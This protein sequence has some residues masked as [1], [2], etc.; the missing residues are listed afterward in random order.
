[1]C[2]FIIISIIFLGLIFWSFWSVIFFRLWDFPSLKVRKCFLFWRSECPKCHHNLT[3]VNLVPVL[4]FLFQWWK[5]AFCKTKI[6]RF[7]PFL[8]ISTVLI[9]LWVYYLTFTDWLNFSL[10]WENY[11]PIFWFLFMIC[12]WLSRLVFLYDVKKLELHITATLFLFVLS[13]ISVF[14]ITTNY[15]TPILWFIIFWIL[16]L[17]VYYLWRLVAFLKYHEDAEGFWFWDVIFSP[18][19]WLRLS[20]LLNPKDWFERGYLV[21]LFLVLSCVI[22]L[23][24]YWIVFLSNLKRKKKKS[25]NK[26]IIPFLPSMII[27]FFVEIFIWNLLMNQWFPYLWG[28]FY[29]FMI[30]S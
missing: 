21:C 13:L 2:L 15:L 29:N 16:F 22:W 8:E 19:I 6:S 17:W 7:Y 24:R 23:A 14:C 20:F 28:L 11:S 27:A 12:A 4:S 18:I 9:F 5:C 30:N 26:K 3:W 1:M 25:D 10:F